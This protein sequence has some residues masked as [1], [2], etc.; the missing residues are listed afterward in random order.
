MNEAQ[1]RLSGVTNS[2]SVLEC[3]AQFTNHGGGRYLPAGS[4]IAFTPVPQ[5]GWFHSVVSTPHLSGVYDGDLRI[6]WGVHSPVRLLGYLMEHGR[7]RE[8]AR[9]IAPVHTL[10]NDVWLSKPDL[11]P[12]SRETWLTH[13]VVEVGAWTGP[14][15]VI[16]I[17]AG[18]SWEALAATVAQR[19]NAD[20]A[21]L[22]PDDARDPESRLLAPGALVF[23]RTHHPGYDDVVA[24]TQVYLP[25]T[26]TLASEGLPFLDRSAD[27][28]ATSFVDPIGDVR[29]WFGDRNGMTVAAKNDI[30]LDFSALLADVTTGTAYASRVASAPPGSPP[31]DTKTRLA[32]P[33]KMRD[34]LAGVD[35]GMLRRSCVG[36]IVLSQINGASRTRPLQLVE[37]RVNSSNPVLSRLADRANR[38]SGLRREP[39]SQSGP[40][41]AGAGASSGYADPDTGYPSDTSGVAAYAAPREGRM[42]LDDVVVRTVGLLFLTGLTAAATWLFVPTDSGVATLALGVGAIGALGLSLLIAF[43]QIT[44]PFVISGFAVLEGLLVGIVS[45]IYSDAFGG[46]IVLQAA[47]GTFAVFF[48]MAAVYKM[49]IIRATPRFTKWLIGLM[50]GAFAL[51][52]LNLGLGLF[53]VNDGEGLSLRSGG[54]VAIVFSIAMIALAAFSFILDFAA[55][56]EGVKL[57][58]PTRYAWYCSFGL[59]VG[60]VWLYFEILRFLGYM[61]D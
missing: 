35:G 49:R 52:L 46:G 37:A 27:G 9:I 56:E 39:V 26:Q 61:R 47:V 21:T 42:T 4:S 32:E 36:A 55:I 22:Y 15:A 33:P 58:L 41:Y 59:L 8:W 40:G 5:E 17:C 60:L 11:A 51:M 38:H 12:K 20:E 48:G 10:L 14:S 53:G 31:G 54:A 6:S 25:I 7:D 50:I 24:G 23:T 45:K 18:T 19:A 2:A 57:G 13:A 43:K 30:D 44:N 28:P 1:R 3:H 29:I 16:P 34:S